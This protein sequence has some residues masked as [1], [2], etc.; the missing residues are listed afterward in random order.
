MTGHFLAMWNKFFSSIP[1][2]WEAI[3]LILC[4]LW[5]R[6]L[7]LKPTP[8]TTL[9]VVVLVRWVAN[10]HPPKHKCTYRT[11]VVSLLTCW[12]MPWEE[13]HIPCWSLVYPQV[14]GERMSQF[15][16]CRF[17]VVLCCDQ[18]DLYIY[19]FITCLKV[20]GQSAFFLVRYLFRFVCFVFLLNRLL[21]KHEVF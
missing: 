15:L 17:V 6:K 4:Q 5:E 19:L 21:S 20:N 13:T 18:W 8:S 11:V 10:N 2:K 16:R 7:K 12:K 1:Q 3:S 9:V 14:K